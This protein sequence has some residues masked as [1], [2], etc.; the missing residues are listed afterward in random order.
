MTFSVRAALTAALLASV[1]APA[2]AEQVFNRIAS[3]PVAGNRS[4]GADKATS[5]E[6]ITATADG[7]TLIYSDAPGGT[8]GFIDI[9]DPK[10]PKAGGSL[11]VEGEPNSV[12]AVGSK[13]LVT[14]DK[15]E[16]MTKPAGALATVDIA[17]QKI[18][19]VCDL[20]GQPDSVVVSP[21]GTFAA[22]AIENQ[23]D[24]ELNDGQIPQL[25]AGELLILALDNGTP[26][27][28]SIKHVD[29]TGL[30]TVAPEDP[31]PEFVNINADGE[32]AV[33]LQENNHVIIVDSK[34]GK[35][36]GHFTAGTVDLDGVDEK[37]DG[38]LDFSG[39][40]DAV[41]REPDAVKWLGTDR[42]VVA[43]EGDYEGGSRG[44]TIFDRTGK[45]LYEAGPSLEH[46]VARLGHF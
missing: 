3:F 8:I 12:A 14:I 46:E 26:T 28:D 29:L 6:I 30:A 33:T 18:E 7:N 24:E 20:G 1:A 45:V 9:T 11:T 10:A 39:K 16:D 34:T 35:V 17:G 23:R 44:F 36:T 38:A 21:D 15:T 19:A 41:P 31:E 4:A 40:L 43:N 22:I 25:P 32:I 13:V 2:G 37:S 5:S 42:L 27:C